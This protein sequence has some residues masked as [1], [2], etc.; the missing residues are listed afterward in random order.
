[1]SRDNNHTKDYAKSI[2]KTFERFEKTTHIPVPQNSHDWNLPRFVFVTMIIQTLK[3]Q[4]GPGNY[5]ELISTMNLLVSLSEP[6]TP[7]VRDK[8]LEHLI[9]CS[10][11]MCGHKRLCSLSTQVF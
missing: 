9:G 6:L 4:P 11:F 1:L 10:L 7:R 5:E 2:K 8:G 3:L